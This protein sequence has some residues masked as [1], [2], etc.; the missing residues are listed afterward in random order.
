M[1]SCAQTFLDF[2]KTYVFKTVRFSVKG[3]FFF[4]LRATTRMVVALGDMFV[5]GEEAWKKG[6]T[7]QT[8]HD[9]H[10]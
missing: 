4:S 6:G 2:R 5:D 7:I 3:A 9:R 8:S 1:Q 10:H